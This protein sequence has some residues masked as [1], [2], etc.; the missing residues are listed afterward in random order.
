MKLSQHKQVHPTG[1]LVLVTMPSIVDLVD[2]LFKQEIK[3]R[4]SCADD[5]L[6]DRSLARLLFLRD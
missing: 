6:K 1:G 4:W 2:T 3:Q 5:H